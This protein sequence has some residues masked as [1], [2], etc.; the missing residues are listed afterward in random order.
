M[1]I[2]TPSLDPKVDSPQKPIIQPG[3][4]QSLR[5]SPT[6]VAD[7]S[8]RRHL[9]R[10][11]PIPLSEYVS[12]QRLA[13]ELEVELDRLKPLIANRYLRILSLKDDMAT[14]VVARP[15][16]E[17]MGWLRTMFM[18][19]DMRPL[20]PVSEVVATFGIS[21]DELRY[22]CVTDNLPIYNDP[23]FGELM[24]VTG[25]WALSKGLVAMRNPLRSDR[26]MLMMVLAQMKNV[27]D[28][29]RLKPLSYSERLE[30]E[31]RRIMK[32]PEPDRTLRAADFFRAYQDA[33]T[34]TDLLE[35][36]ETVPTG[37]QK[38]IMKRTETMQKRLGN[39]GSKKD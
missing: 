16:P 1:P 6:S 37:R 26:Q 39:Q 20:I 5:D 3:T 4:S 27:R 24:S 10:K 8:L 33:N 17:A 19:L 31:I 30:S 36:Y 7:R 11:S 38:R 9:L 25:F 12:L 18:P 23:V 13:D 32:L 22:I 34:L 15:S 2:I 35:K 28:L 21:E 14:T 29:G